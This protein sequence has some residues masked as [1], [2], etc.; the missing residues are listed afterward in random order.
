MMRD[1]GAKEQ[2]VLWKGLSRENM[3]E[4][5]A[6]RHNEVFKI[7]RMCY[8]QNCKIY[9]YI[10]NI[11]VHGLSW[12]ALTFGSEK[13]LMV[14]IFIVQWGV[15]SLWQ[16]YWTVPKNCCWSWLFGEHPFSVMK[17]LQLKKRKGWHGKKHSRF[18]RSDSNKYS[19][20]H[21]EL[22]IGPNSIV[23]DKT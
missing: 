21:K 7:S 16:A 1:R 14:L 8:W 11:G 22:L 3:R 5:W 6:L 15:W 9:I 10:K 4:F 13:C 23:A 19:G 18:S 17:E 2:K 12:E 20:L